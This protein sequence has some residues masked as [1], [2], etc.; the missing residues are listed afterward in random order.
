MKNSRRARVTETIRQARVS[1]IIRADD[2]GRAGDAMQ[3]AVEGGFHVVEFTLTTPGALSLVER[4]SAAGTLTV[5]AGTVMSPGAAADAVSAGAEFLVSPIFDADV[6]AEAAK[7]DV[8]I[9]PG[10]YTPTEMET[11]HRH[12]ADFIKVF[13]APA[14]GV[15]FIHAIRGPLPHLPLFPTAGPTPENFIEYLEAGCAGVGFVRSLFDPQDMARGDLAA[16]RARAEKI[17]RRL[18]DWKSTPAK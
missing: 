18:K 4:F 5:G 10:C 12:G 16:V 17:I 9:I 7:L 11:A 6:V 3:A 1:A 14:G 13:P 8:P 2:E 15:G